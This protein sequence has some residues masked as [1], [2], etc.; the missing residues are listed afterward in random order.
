M[1]QFDSRKK[2]SLAHSGTF[3]NN[4]F[5]MT[6]GL[7]AFKVVT[8]EAIQRTNELGTTLMTNLKSSLAAAG[9]DQV[10]VLGYGSAVSLHFADDA[11][12][13]AWYFFMLSEGI[14]LGRRGSIYLNLAHVSGDVNQFISA[15]DTFCERYKTL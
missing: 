8:P 6:A 1:E 5:T 13:D 4:V 3:N 12:R 7:A 2:G 15:V 11:L 9:L 14:Y 10:Q